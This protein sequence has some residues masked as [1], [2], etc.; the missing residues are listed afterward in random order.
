MSSVATQY[1]PTTS[2]KGGWTALPDVTATGG[3]LLPVAGIEL[4]ASIGDK[5]RYKQGGGFKYGYVAAVGANQIGLFGGSDY[6]VTPSTA[7]TELAISHEANPFGFPSY[8]NIT[9]SGGQHPREFRVVRY[10]LDL[11]CV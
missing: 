4:I 6:S 11:P 3:A 10:Y 8:F 7:V 9:T 1:V 5:V 2:E